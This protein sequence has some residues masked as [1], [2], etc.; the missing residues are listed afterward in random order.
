MI[1]TLR[2]S[3]FQDHVILPSTSASSCVKQCVLICRV[4][5]LKIFKY[6]SQAFKWWQFTP[7]LK[8]LHLCISSYILTNWTVL[9]LKILVHVTFRF[10]P[11]TSRV[12][13]CLG[14]ILVLEFETIVNELK[15]DV[16]LGPALNF[17]HLP[18][19]P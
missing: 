2:S 10:C 14:A 16:S 4:V 13:R 7:S 12:K 19:P 17:S 6:F 15:K 5:G 11:S 3:E 1:S 9:E 8:S 18:F